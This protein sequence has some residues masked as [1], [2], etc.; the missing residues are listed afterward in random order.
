MG[1]LFKRV[2]LAF[3]AVLLVL[4]PL[5]TPVVHAVE[6]WSGESWEG[7]PWD[8]SQLQ[9]Q[10]EDWE[11]SETEGTPWESNPID[12]T[13]WEGETGE[14]NPWNQDGFNNDGSWSGYDWQLSPWYMNGWAQP[15]MNGDPWSNDGFA[16]DPTQGSPWA[17][18]D[19][20]MGE[21]SGDPWRN[22]GF[23]GNENSIPPWMYNG[24]DPQDTSIDTSSYDVGKFLVNDVL[25]GQVD[26]M[27]H[28]DTHQNMTDRNYNQSRNYGIGYRSNIFVNGLR[29]GID[30]NV[31]LDTADNVLNTYNAAQGIRTAADIVSYE[32]A[33]RNSQAYRGSIDRIEDLASISQ[34]TSNPNPSPVS[35]G[36]LSKL[37]VAAAAV[38][39]GFSA[40]DTG[41]ST[42]EAYNVLT[43]ENA[44]G[45]E[46]TSATAR[47]GEGAGN[48]LMNAGMVTAVV[49]GMQ[50]AGGIM[51]GVGAGLWA[52]SRGT[53]FVAD[54]WKGNI[55]DTGKA[56]VNSA[57]DT[58]KKTWST[59]KGWFS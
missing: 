17:G 57:K 26:L 28:L 7:D 39:A 14:G 24:Y 59:V 49:P 13:P 23:S 42:V 50:A 34:R 36:A 29:L 55:K 15:G 44:S 1:R 37:N 9:W 3:I 40:I 22:T 30:D 38:G 20:S 12:G 56:M 31:A 52:V 48:T 10:G 16:G 41:I 11:G 45:A 19:F 53:R 43:S 27:G 51:I 32:Q 54:H 6:P 33:I 2:I 58:A 5:I 35:V 4:H 47:V 18:N 21:M 8:G 46:M 25:M